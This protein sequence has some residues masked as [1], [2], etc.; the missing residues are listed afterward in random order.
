MKTQV[1]LFVRTGLSGANLSREVPRT[2]SGRTDTATFGSRRISRL[3]EQCHPVSVTGPGRALPEESALH[4]A[5]SSPSKS[6]AC[7][8]GKNPKQAVKGHFPLSVLGQHHQG[9]RTVVKTKREKFL[10]IYGGKG[11]SSVPIP[12]QAPQATCIVGSLCFFSNSTRLEAL[13]A[14]NSLI[15]GQH[16]GQITFTTKG[17]RIGGLGSS[18]PRLHAGLSRG[19]NN[20]RETQAK[21]RGP[22]PKL[23]APF[24]SRAFADAQVFS[25]PKGG[26]AANRTPLLENPP[27]QT[28]RCETQ[29]FSNSDVTF[30]WLPQRP[31]DRS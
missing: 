15:F 17:T 13:W 11:A 31:Q 22:C 18:A 20:H 4:D 16:R 14:R 25:P 5:P 2:S 24:S 21:G 3:W 6:L 12:D 26:N 30:A 9:E 1:G 28:H 7:F 23:F 29:V 8:T 27:E 19:E 10:Q